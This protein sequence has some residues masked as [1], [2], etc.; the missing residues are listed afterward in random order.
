[1]FFLWQ[2]GTIMR[3]LSIE[4]DKSNLSLCLIVLQYLYFQNAEEVEEAIY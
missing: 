2:R 3:A 1:M 4:S